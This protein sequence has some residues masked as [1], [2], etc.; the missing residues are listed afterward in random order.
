MSEGMLVSSSAILLGYKLYEE[1]NLK[2]LS[3]IYQADKCQK[4][5]IFH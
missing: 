4:I 2:N 1:L 5:C 3:G